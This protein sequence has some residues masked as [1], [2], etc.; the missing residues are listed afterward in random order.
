MTE[1][2][3]KPEIG[4]L[5]ESIKLRNDAFVGMLRFR[6]WRWFMLACGFW[7]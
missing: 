3:P 5:M 4:P 6:T 2:W 1:V 7:R